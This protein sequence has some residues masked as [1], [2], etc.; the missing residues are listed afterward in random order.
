MRTKNPCCAG[1]NNGN[2]CG[3]K[4]AAETER[5]T[6]DSGR[7]FTIDFVSEISHGFTGCTRLY[8]N[9][10]LNYLARPVRFH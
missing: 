6:G 4:D 1:G 10:A 2:R 3:T 9:N 5:R 7:N 8:L